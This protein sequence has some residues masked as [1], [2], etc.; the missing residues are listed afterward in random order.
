MTIIDIAYSPSRTAARFHASDAF[1]RGIRGPIGSG[2]SVAC[3]LEMFRI[4]SLQ[5]VGKDGKRRSRWAG[6]RNC[7][8]DKT[9]ILTENGWKLFKDV[10]TR[11]KVAMLAE[12]GQTVFVEPTRHY[13]APYRGDMVGFEGEGAD[14][15]VTPDHKMMVSRL[16]GR[17]KTWGGWEFEK[18]ADLYGKRTARVLRSSTGWD[19]EPTEFS[20]DQFEWLGFWFAEGN[21]GVTLGRDGSWRRRLIVTQCKEA[22]IRYTRDLFQRAEIDYAES[23]RCD[24]GA[25][26]R[27][28]TTRFNN[29]NVGNRLFDLLKGCG[30]APEKRLPRWI[31]NAP[32]EH[33]RR[34]I[35]GFMNGDG[36]RGASAIAFTSSKRLA[37]DLQEV[38][39]RAGMV[40]NVRS[41]NRVGKA[42]VVGDSVGKVNAVEWTVTFVREQKHRP[43]LQ[44]QVGRYRGWYQEQ[45][46]SMVYCIEVPT[47]KVYVRRNGV[48]MWCSQT[49][50]ELK[51]TTIKT[52]QDWFPE[53]ISPFLWDS[54]IS[55]VL[56]LGDIVMEVYFIALD[57]PKDIRKLKSL[58]L[59]GVW[60]NEASEISKSVL[61]MATGRV[62]RYPALK[63]GGSTRSCVIMDTNPPDVDHWWYHVA[64]EA[65][66]EG[67]EF[68]AQ[69]PAMLEF[70]AKSGAYVPNPAAENIGNHNEGYEYYARQIPGKKTEWIKVFILGQYGTVLDGRPVYPEY[71]DA[72]HC[73]E[74]DI[75]TLRGLPLYIGIDFGRTPAAVVLQVTPR[76]QVRIIDEVAVDADGVGMGL[77][78]FARDVLRPHLAKHYPGMQSHLMGDPSG[79]AKD[80]NDL[81]SFD[82]LAEEKLPAEP[83]PTN[84][85]VARQDAVTKHLQ[86]HV[87]GEP[88]L[89]VSP[90]CKLVRK[91]FLGGYRMRR[92]QI[93]GSEMRFQDKPDKNKYSH[94]HDAV[95]YGAMLVNG[96]V[97][98]TTRA[99]AQPVEVQSAAG[100]S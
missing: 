40:A 35:D 75:P 18:A 94:P 61:D 2:K 64:E 26:F 86:S 77:R 95:Q 39:L 90:K 21:V 68:F 23:L 78:K 69:P 49:Y 70:P 44:K 20:L 4:A 53:E 76:G 36:N 11:E 13:C 8:D 81:S 91:G 56:E 51:S 96:L 52:Y 34:F 89:L 10:G 79:V 33:L 98:A 25:A 15:L 9:E 46:D 99:V 14:F 50:P 65:R 82:I 6:I 16:R 100:W 43:I 27:V 47:H 93:A 72:I 19:G 17:S 7:Y 87:D 48:G 88:G 1:V 85:P 62:G 73:A 12:N 24:G 84:D 32:R 28:R 66:P 60:L 38:A 31:K 97:K 29:G 45:Y 67:W 37:D 59:T 42:V 5:K 58:E 63:D 3:V 83:A 22:G 54:P 57:L 30:L 41:R 55:T 71:N 92:M 74:A 80:G